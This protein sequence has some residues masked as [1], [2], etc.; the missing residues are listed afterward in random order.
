MGRGVH[1]LEADRNVGCEWHLL[2]VQVRYNNLEIILANYSFSLLRQVVQALGTFIDR[3]INQLL[4]SLLQQG[5]L[6]HFQLRNTRATPGFSL[7]LIGFGLELI[8][9]VWSEP[10][11]SLDGVDDPDLVAVDAQLLAR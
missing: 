9:Q 8:L 7:H 2:F 4:T 5:L 11:L 3:A 10:A 6:E 1:F